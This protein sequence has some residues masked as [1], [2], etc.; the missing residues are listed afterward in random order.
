MPTDK[1]SMQ[2]NDFRAAL[3]ALPDMSGTKLVNAMPSKSTSDSWL[4]INIMLLKFPRQTVLTQ[5]GAARHRA[6]VMTDWNGL[7]QCAEKY[8]II[9]AASI[10][11]IKQK[12]AAIQ[13]K[14]LMYI[15]EIL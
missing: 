13:I 5:T 14:S 15:V 10:I 1:G 12:T 9:E 7:L 2:H 3:P 8:R 11:P 6:D 4:A